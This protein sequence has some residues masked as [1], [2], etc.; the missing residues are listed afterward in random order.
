MVRDVR[1][2]NR[3]GKTEGTQTATI[4]SDEIFNTLSK[5]TDPVNPV[6]MF[7]QDDAYPEFPTLD[8]EPS[9]MS[10]V[11]YDRTRFGQAYQ[12]GTAWSEYL[13]FLERYYINRYTGTIINR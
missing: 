6:G 9:R 8:G 4:S 10:F 12:R 11:V 13:Q 3:D 7:V 1:V 2:R 5:I